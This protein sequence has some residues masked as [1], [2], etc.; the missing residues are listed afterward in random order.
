M[1]N[2]A[3]NICVNFCVEVYFISF[4]N[5]P[6]SG[7]TGHMISPCLI[8]WE[9][10]K[11]YFKAAATYTFIPSVCE[12][13]NF[14]Y[15]HCYLLLSFFFFGYRQPSGYE[16]VFHVSLMVSNADH[17]SMC[18]FMS[19][20]EKCLFE[21]FAHLKKIDVFIISLSLSC[22]YILETNPLSDL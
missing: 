5:L 21:S 7:I 8:F 9:I 18:L 2:V 14:S 17:L 6:R 3:V 13:S 19:S 15:L 12:G 22:L 4:V 16:G 11:Q 10:V 1:N 20:S